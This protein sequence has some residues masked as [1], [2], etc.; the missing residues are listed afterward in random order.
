MWR[1]LP[2]FRVE[3]K[4]AESC[5][6]SGCHGVPIPQKIDPP[7]PGFWDTPF[8]FSQLSTRTRRSFLFSLSEVNLLD[9]NREPGHSFSRLRVNLE[10]GQRVHLCMERIA[11]PERAADIRPPHRQ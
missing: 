1:K 2:D 7:P 8:T 10:T 3:K 6:V 11:L 5:R 9:D 4:S